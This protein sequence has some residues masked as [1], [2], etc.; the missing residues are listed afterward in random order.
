MSEIGLVPAMAPVH[1][2]PTNDAAAYRLA[3]AVTRL[4]RRMRRARAGISPS[5]LSALTTIARL[6]PLRLGELATQEM[7][8]PPTLTRVVATLEERG[9]V[10]RRADP[11][12]ARSSLIEA[13]ADGLRLLAEVGEEFVGMLGVAIGL[14]PADD[15]ERLRAALPAIE[16]LADEH[17]P[18][19][20][21][22]PRS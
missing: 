18:V 22:A 2:D 1:R 21:D 10:T 7:V 17:T 8:S 9:V 15:R 20:P 11:T 13:N 3:M 19:P 5:Q 14:L 4:T 12:D 16:H 6:G